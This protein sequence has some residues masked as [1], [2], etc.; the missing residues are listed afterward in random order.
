MLRE[1]DRRIA[2]SFDRDLPEAAQLLGGDPRAWSFLQEGINSGAGEHCLGVDS[3]GG[4]HLHDATKPD[5]GSGPFAHSALSRPG[6]RSRANRLAGSVNDMPEAKL[7]SA[8][9][10]AH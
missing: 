5:C 7:Y 3:L 1:P 2:R 6:W 4:E 9:R 8:Q 10:T